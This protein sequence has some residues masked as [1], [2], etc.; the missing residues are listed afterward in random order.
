[1]TELETKTPAELIQ[2][3]GALQTQRAKA[4]SIAV[5]LLETAIDPDTKLLAEQMVA[6]L[7]PL[8]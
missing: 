7:E 4:H 2:M 5:H 6:D 1:M 8:Q 3:I